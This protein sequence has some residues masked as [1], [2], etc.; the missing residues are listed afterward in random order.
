MNLIAAQN[1]AQELMGKHGLFGDVLWRDSQ[2]PAASWPWRFQFDGARR[3]FGLCSY[4]FKM[5]FL[6]ARLVELNDE[7]EVR[8]TILHEIAH[9]LNYLD[10]KARL[11]RAPKS[12]HGPAWKAMCRRIGARPETCYSRDR[13][14][15]PSFLWEATC[16]HCGTHYFHEG[17][18][19]PDHKLCSPCAKLGMQQPKY[20]VGDYLFPYVRGEEIIQQPKKVYA[21][22]TFSPLPGVLRSIGANN[23]L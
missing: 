20:D 14:A 11:G 7:A 3:R 23:G 9:A 17:L 6:S 13:V 12:H 10:V 2:W 5:I 16:K 19:S 18:R 1:M 22:G 15:T 4:K 8:D 21:P